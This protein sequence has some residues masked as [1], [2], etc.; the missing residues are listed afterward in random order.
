M[1]TGCDLFWEQ[2]HLPDSQLI[3]NFQEKK[4]DFEHLRQMILEDEGL[5]RV[6]VDWTE[7]RDPQTV[8]ISS[9][10]IAE[11]RKMFRRLGTPRGFSA[12]RGR[13]NIEFIASSQG[14]VTHGSHKSYAYLRD[15]PDTLL[16]SLD[17]FIEP[18]K[19]RAVGTGYRHI[20]GNWY[21]YFYGD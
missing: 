3:A 7:P 19:K 18:S 2:S 14:F 9:E 4:A 8:G 16:D 13:S 1:L 10:R 11:Y 20:E 6:D 15:R 21:L 17:G 5:T 12:T